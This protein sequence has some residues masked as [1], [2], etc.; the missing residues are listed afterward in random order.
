MTIMFKICRLFLFTACLIMISGI[1]PVIALE[2]EDLL[3]GKVLLVNQERNTKD[4][5]KKMNLGLLKVNF[6][7]SVMVNE[8]LVGACTKSEQKMIGFISRPKP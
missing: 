2:Q 3:D 7:R 4:P 5:L 1:T 8:A 6:T